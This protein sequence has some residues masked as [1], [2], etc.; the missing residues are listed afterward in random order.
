MRLALMVVLAVVLGLGAGLVSGFLAVF[1]GLSLASSLFGESRLLP[2]PPV[3]TPAAIVCTEVL[4]PGSP[5]GVSPS[6][7][8]QPRE[9]G[10][11]KC[12]C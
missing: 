4:N 9:L 8:F 5:D 3:A 2:S 7:A 10:R 6:P 12:F 11:A 1:V